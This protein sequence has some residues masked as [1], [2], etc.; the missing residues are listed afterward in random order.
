MRSPASHYHP[1]NRRSADQAGKLRALVDL[2]LQL[3]EPARA[4]GIDIIG[5]G[6]SAQ[7]DCLAEH[8]LQTLAKTIHA[9]PAKA[10]RSAAGPDAGAEEALIGIDVA[11]PLQ[12][13]L[14]EQR[15]FDRGSRAGKE[16]GK[17][18]IGD[19]QWFSSAARKAATLL[20]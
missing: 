14:I 2:M 6:R 4:V 8:L 18:V 16:S 19:G 12:T 13:G 10:G 1:A 9:L 5:H 7:G 20:R 3:K 17:F 15:G 11:H